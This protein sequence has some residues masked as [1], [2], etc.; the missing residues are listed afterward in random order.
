MSA[1]LRV[2]SPMIVSE[3]TDLPE[4]DSPTIPSVSPG[5]RERDAVDGLDHA[6]VGL[7]VHREVSDLQQRLSQHLRVAVTLGIEERVH[8]VHDEV[9]PRR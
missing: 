7:E 9:R 3:L 2:T 1:C 4:P 6:V 8:D 5:D